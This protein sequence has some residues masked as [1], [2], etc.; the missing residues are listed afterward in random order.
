[1]CRKERDVVV[2]FPCFNMHL[3]GNCTSV[4]ETMWGQ[5][6][7]SY[8]CSLAQIIPIFSASGLCLRVECPLTAPTGISCCKS[9]QISCHCLLHSRTSYF[10]SL[11]QLMQLC[12]MTSVP[13]QNMVNLGESWICIILLTFG[14]TGICITPLKYL[15]YI[16]SY[17]HLQYFIK[18]YY[19]E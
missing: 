7:R 10:P 14:E 1:M 11:S 6:A 16:F 5:R 2:P 4:L 15:P 12:C 17:I 9:I 3:W 18:L 8:S 19:F 13:L